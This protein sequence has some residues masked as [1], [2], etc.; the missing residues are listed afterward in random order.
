MMQYKNIYLA[1]DAAI[2]E[3]AALIR[4]GSLVAFP[5]E[6]VYGLGADAR[7]EHAVAAIF[8]AKGRPQFNPLIVHVCD[9]AAARALAEFDPLSLRLAQ[10]FW[11]GPFTLVLARRKDC[12]LSLLVSAGLDTVAL[13]V[14]AH[15]LAQALLREAG[16]PIAA[17]SANI[18]G[19][20]S[21]TSAAHV[22]AELGD[23]VAMIL[24]GGVCAVGLEST[25]VQVRDAQVFLLRPG[26]VTRDQICAIAGPLENISDAQ[27]A[28]V[29]PGQL[30]SHYAPD[31]PLRLNAMTADPHEAALGFGE[32]IPVGAAKICNL[33]AGGDL[34]EA[35]ANLFAMLRELD[36]DQFTGI[37]VA[38]IPAHGLGEAINDRLSRAAC[39]A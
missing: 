35:A 8:A 33:S 3:A 20:I 29:S 12:A 13:R 18:S 2:D 30:A 6:T 11:P 37:A 14:P 5:T 21:P 26:S 22:A 31:L 4:A 1:N 28:P 32:N 16:C 25:V 10:K 19:R 9:L 27:A 24:D 34:T 38:P 23:K 17:P 15:P 7:S 39:R 36:C